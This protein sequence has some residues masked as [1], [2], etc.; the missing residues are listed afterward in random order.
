[1]EASRA[2]AEAQRLHLRTQ[3]ALETLAEE[4][5]IESEARIRDALQRVEQAQQAAARAQQ[6]ALGGGARALGAEEAAARAADLGRE[7]GPI[8]W[9]SPECGTASLVRHSAS[10][11]GV[12][13]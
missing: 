1:M 3:S 2:A 4:A 6:E 9:A 11:P 8:R 10:K 7:W 13:S 12:S 5:I